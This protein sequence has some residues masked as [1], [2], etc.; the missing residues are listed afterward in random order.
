MPGRCAGPCDVTNPSW[1]N[2]TDE[3]REIDP[4]NQMPRGE[5]VL[6]P[7]LRLEEQGRCCEVAKIK[8]VLHS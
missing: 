8:G 1:E 6:D 4:D 2:P 7:V 5:V 3:E